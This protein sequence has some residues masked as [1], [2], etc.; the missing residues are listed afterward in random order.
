LLDGFVV[1]RFGNNAGFLFLAGCALAALVFFA[2]LMPET[3]PANGATAASPSPVCPRIV[4]YRLIF[5]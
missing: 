3:R 2:L 5:T 4:Y 1:A